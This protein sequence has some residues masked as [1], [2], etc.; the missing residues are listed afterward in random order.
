MV[1]LEKTLMYRSSMRLSLIGLLII[2]INSCGVSQNSQMRSLQPESKTQIVD[3]LK[4]LPASQVLSLKYG[5]EQGF[6]EV[7]CELSPSPGIQSKMSPLPNL[8]VQQP[9]PHQLIYNL[10][11]QLSVDPDLSQSVEVKLVSST[12]EIELE[13]K[14]KPVYFSDLLNVQY[15]SARYILQYTPVLEYELSYQINKGSTTEQGFGTG[16]ILEKIDHTVT[17]GSSIESGSFL[18]RLFC[19]METALN[20]SDLRQ[21]EEFQRQWSCVGCLNIPVQPGQ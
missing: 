10:N 19:R 7:S 17:L 18:H 8:P 14:F 2:T 3:L 9:A 12:P 1:E 16:R 13:L 4:G 5:G 15:D 6:I 11:L 21:Y 20:R